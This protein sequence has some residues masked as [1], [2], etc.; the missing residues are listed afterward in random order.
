M[1]SAQPEP[2]PSDHHPHQAT[3]P[4]GAATTDAD[5]ERITRLQLRYLFADAL[6]DSLDIADLREVA[7]AAGITVQPGMDAGE[8]REA[9]RASNAAYARSIGVP[10]DHLPRLTTQQAYDLARLLSGEPAPPAAPA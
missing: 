8:L 3:P 10:I 9:I 7:T 5:K 2:R 1:T 4:E 6:L